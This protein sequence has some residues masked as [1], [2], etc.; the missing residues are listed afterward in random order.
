M[1]AGAEE[2]IKRVFVRWKKDRFT[3]LVEFVGYNGIA[4]AQTL[5]M[6][7]ISRPSLTSAISERSIGGTKASD[8]PS[9]PC[10]ED[11]DALP[12]EIQ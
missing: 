7:T 10:K 11:M 6:R 1:V 8:L 9:I 4:F 5:N 3:Q 12:E 2:V